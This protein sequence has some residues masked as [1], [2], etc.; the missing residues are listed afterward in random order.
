MSPT[1][2]CT[3]EHCENSGIPIEVPAA[4]ILD[5]VEYPVT[6]IICGPC[7]ATIP[8]PEAVT[9]GDLD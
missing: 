6:L 3:T 4:T 5:G 9:H 2:V 8:L 1:V 7:G